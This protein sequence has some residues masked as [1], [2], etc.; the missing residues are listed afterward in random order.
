MT[1]TRAMLRRLPGSLVLVSFQFALGCGGESTQTGRRSN[2][3]GTD[4]HGGRRLEARFIESADG[5]G[6]FQHFYDT[7]LELRCNFEPIEADVWRCTPSSAEAARVSE[8]VYADA[9]CTEPHAA[10][11][12]TSDGLEGC[13]PPRY[14]IVGDSCGATPSVFEIG[15]PSSVDSWYRVVDGVCAVSTLGTDYLMTLYAVTPISLEEFQV[16]R[17]ITGD[18][19]EGIVPV[20]LSS[21]DGARLRRGF[22]DALEGFDCRVGAPDER[23]LPTEAG[24]MGYLF[25][26]A[27]CTLPA[28][29]PLYCADQLPLLPFAQDL[30]PDGTIYHRGGARLSTSYA[31]SPGLCEPSANSVA[32]EVGPA[33]PN[34]RFAAGRRATVVGGD[35]EVTVETVGTAS[36]PAQS[37]QSTAH[38]GYV[39]HAARGSDGELRCLPPPERY[40]ADFFADT[41]CSQRVESTQAE[42]LAVDSGVCP[43]EVR[44]FARGDRYTGPVY[45]VTEGACALA[46]DRPP[47]D[48]ERTP[49]YVFPSEIPAADFT[50]LYEV[51]R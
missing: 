8:L 35:L 19:T 9:E 29:M 13:T 10:L 39:C 51:T 27:E 12:P 49:H 15:S 45:A 48:S 41:E 40:L 31:G 11:L 47:N 30:S 32:F 20:D 5:I 38:G 44:V 22:R 6:V 25:A 21:D 2:E 36:L 1:N 50:R 4:T 16:G 43:P 28:A 7:E 24:V 17:L 34:T 42:V 14:A 37:L 26:D 3:P 33:I 18:E 23:C 46:H